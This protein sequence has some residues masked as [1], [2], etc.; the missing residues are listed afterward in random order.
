MICNLVHHNGS[1]PCALFERK[2]NTTI[3]EGD[4]LL[5]QSQIFSILIFLF[6]LAVPARSKMGRERKPLGKKKLSNAEKQKRWERNKNIIK[7]KDQKRKKIS[8]PK[9]K[10]FVH[11][12]SLFLKEQCVSWLFRTKYFE[13]KLQLFYLPT[14]SWT[15]FLSWATTRCPPS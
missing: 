1:W 3:E 11:F 12:F 4:F 7:E 6:Q 13:K 10:A 9:F 8:Q 5:S 15:F 14:V 2:N